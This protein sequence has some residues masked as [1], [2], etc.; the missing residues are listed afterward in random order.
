MTVEE[1]IASIRGNDEDAR[2]KAWMHAGPLGA[3]AIA[4]LAPLMA[5]EDT[6]TRR[7]AV[8]A[9]WKVVRHAGRPGAGAEAS[10]VSRE[11]VVLISGDQSEP[12]KREAVWM[13]SEISGDEAVAPLARLLMDRDLGEHARAALQRIPGDKSLAAL[14]DGFAAAPTER[15]A[16]IAESLH[17]RGVEVSGFTCRKL[18]PTKSTNVKPVGR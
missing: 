12:V 14:K 11:L 8:R 17:R 2:A 4:P 15:K 1:L 7:A 16:A 13:A 5:A 6:E 3:A 18:V 9:A 10:A